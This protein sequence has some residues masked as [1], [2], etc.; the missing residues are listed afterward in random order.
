MCESSSGLV[1][2]EEGD[3]G[4]VKEDMRARVNGRREREVGGVV[5]ARGV[6]KGRR[7]QETL[8]RRA[9]GLEADLE[10]EDAVAV[11]DRRSPTVASVV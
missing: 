7:T 2:P 10:S 1:D 8:E 9:D 5:T 3:R 6:E 4:G 11:R